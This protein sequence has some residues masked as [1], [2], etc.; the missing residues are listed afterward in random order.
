M[1]DVFADGNTRVAWITAIAN[2]NAPSVAELN[3]GTLL[4]DIMTIDGLMGFQA[5]TQPVPSTPLS[6]VFD[7]EQPGSVQVK[8]NAV[9]L[10]KQNAN[11]GTDAIFNLLAPK[12]L[13]FVAIRKSLA[14][15]TA[16]ASGQLAQIY[17]AATGYETYLALERDTLERYEIPIFITGQPQLRAVVA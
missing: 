11:P 9:R 15:A 6:G 1:T 12:T 16:W 13:G 5:E 4:H 8:G 17:P 7:T 14:A 10:K 3:A 2:I